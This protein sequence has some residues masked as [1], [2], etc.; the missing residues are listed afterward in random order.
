MTRLPCVTTLVFSLYLTLT[1]IG[2]TKQEPT[3]LESKSVPSVGSSRQSK[4]DVAL[5]EPPGKIDYIQ[6][7][8]TDLLPDEDLEALEN[9][10]EYLDDIEDGSESDQLTSQLKAKP[11]AE[12][13][14]SNNHSAAENR[15]EQALTSQKIRPEFN[16]RPIRIPGFIVPLE[17]DDNQTI[18]TFFFVPF[19]GACIHMPP[20]PP[21][22]IIYA[23]Y[24]P[25]IQLDA[26]YDPFWVNGTL[27]TTLIENDMATA[28]YSITVSSIEPYTDFTPQDW[29][30]NIEDEVTD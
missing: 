1:G 30:R 23:E 27:S 22:Q 12:I 21:N 3:K 10:P 24:E 11:T 13:I 18:T 28:A 9:P 20:P 19:F 4:Q 7:Q 8:W 16:G 17:F 15:Y 2:C 5:S 14:A 6:I 25:G 29:D 26:L